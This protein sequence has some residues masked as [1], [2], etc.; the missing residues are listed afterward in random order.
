MFCTSVSSRYPVS[1]YSHERM[2]KNNPKIKRRVTAT[3]HEIVDNSFIF[4]NTD[5]GRAF[6]FFV[7]LFLFV[8]LYPLHYSCKRNQV[9]LSRSSLESSLSLDLNP[10]ATYHMVLSTVPWANVLLYPLLKV[11]SRTTWANVENNIFFW[12][13]ENPSRKID[14]LI[15]ITIRNG[16]QQ[17]QVVDHLVFVF[18]TDASVQVTVVELIQ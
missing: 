12:N 17:R 14:R 1:R 2:A 18:Q 8:F 3:S 9:L 6:C 11:A 10:C 15:P 7:F 5:T 4:L 13:L 16:F